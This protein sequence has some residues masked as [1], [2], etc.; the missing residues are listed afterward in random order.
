MR[1]FV[2]R[3]WLLAIAGVSVIAAGSPV[4]EAA[5]RAGPQPP[6]CAAA[7]HLVAAADADLAEGAFEPAIAGYEDAAARC[8]TPAFAAAL[9]FKLGE[10]HQRR[11]EATVLALAADPEDERLDPAGTLESTLA[12]R[13]AAADDRRRA[14]ALFRD[15]VHATPRGPLVTDARAHLA[16]LRRAL[17]GDEA[18]IDAT[19]ARLAQLGATDPP[20]AVSP[21]SR[22]GTA[23][24]AWRTRWVVTA[25]V[26]AA[27]SVGLAAVSGYQGMHARDLTRRLEY[28]TRWG[29]TENALDA[30]RAR[31]RHQALTLGAASGVAAIAATVLF[32]YARDTRSTA[33]TPV[34]TDHGVA[35]AGEF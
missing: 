32:I 9:A 13:Q 24:T 16:A 11:A 1:R 20:G 10:A 30:E 34:V 23:R 22:P 8:A 18:A 4:A 27:T 3:G 33:V 12:G 26:L 7:E 29:P 6:G 21:R 5:P 15:Y 25:G 14:I 31:V 35:L 28:A 17:A 19:R 2:L